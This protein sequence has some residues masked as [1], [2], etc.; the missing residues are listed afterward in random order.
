MKPDFNAVSLYDYPDL[1]AALQ[2]AYC[3]TCPFNAFLEVS[4]K[5][6][7][8]VELHMPMRPELIGN[9]HRKMLHGGVIAAYLDNV[10]G[11]ASGMMVVKR[12]LAEGVAWQEAVKALTRHA[13]I[14]L[15]TDFL[16][17]GIGKKFIGRAEVIRSGSRINVVR[18]E[19]LNDAGELIA[20]GTGAFRYS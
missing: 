12:R 4:I 8:P 17:P 1:L 13:T 14:D 10:C 2:N 20:L 18:G 15:R 7:D 11:T 3:D 16:Q 9:A 6:L 5:S 19:L